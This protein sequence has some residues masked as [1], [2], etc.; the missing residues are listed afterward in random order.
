MPWQDQVNMRIR[1]RQLGVPD[2][3][4]ARDSGASPYGSVE[5]VQA[6]GDAQIAKQTGYGE[7]ATQDYLGR[8]EHFD[9]SKALNTYAGGAWNTIRAGL[10]QQLAAEEGRAV[11]AGRFDSGFLDEDK[12]VVINRA[13]D[14]LANSI[15]GQSMNALAAEQRNT[16]GLGSFAN[17]RT[18]MG[19][20]LLMARS[21]QVQNDARAEAERRRKKN[22]GVGS[23]I[24]GVLGA[25]AGSFVPGIGT[26]AG[27]GAGSAIGAGIGGG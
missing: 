14:Q 25:A 12:G 21:E 19:N 7:Q 11:G 8:A 23:L 2:T 1:R 13:T 4:A 26:A 9:A 15:A 3:P 20:E 10:G 17:Q 27:W 16:E 24:G 5:G 6:A 22:S 18:E